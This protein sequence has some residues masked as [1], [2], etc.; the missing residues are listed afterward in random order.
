L[1]QVRHVA[2]LA[3][4][5]LNDQQLELYR[6][7]LATV[8]EHIDKLSELDVTNVEPMAHPTDFS[9]RLADDVVGPTMP[10]DDLLRNAPETEDRFLA[11]P[12]V[13]ADEE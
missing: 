9:N 12:K 2:K 10:I 3:R 11:V 8:L 1:D 5:Q 13:L 6:N 7:Q 4:L